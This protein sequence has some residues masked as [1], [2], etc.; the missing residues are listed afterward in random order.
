M[1]IWQENA[2]RFHGQTPRNALHLS[3]GWPVMAFPSLY[4]GD[5]SK[6]VSKKNQRPDNHAISLCTVLSGR[7]NVIR[8]FGSA[9]KPRC[10]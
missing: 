7:N 1:S 5:L 2:F 4:V 6:Q 9:I 8:A 3:S 10:R